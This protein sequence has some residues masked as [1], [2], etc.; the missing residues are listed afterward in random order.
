VGRLGSVVGRILVRLPP[1]HT[2]AIGRCEATAFRQE[3]HRMDGMVNRMT[4]RGMRGLPG[5]VILFTIPSILCSSC[6]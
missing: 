4:G 3:E 2:Q 6:L 1:T 5:P